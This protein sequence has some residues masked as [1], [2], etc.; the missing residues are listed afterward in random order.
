M[1]RFLKPLCI[2]FLLTP[3]PGMAQS[4]PP[5]VAS[6]AI[7]ASAHLAAQPDQHEHVGDATYALMAAQAQGKQAGAELPV[8][9]A[10]AGLTWKRYLDTFK[11]PVPDWFKEK[12][13]TDG[14]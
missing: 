7:G 6:Q 12:V 9:G 13:E 10:T 5:L 3:A 4:N 11:H 14:E 1:T 8:L 2:L